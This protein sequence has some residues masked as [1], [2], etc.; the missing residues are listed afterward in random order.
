MSFPSLEFTF[1][2]KEQA[3][4][5]A[6]FHGRFS[7]ARISLSTLSGRSSGLII[8]CGLLFTGEFCKEE[9]G[10]DTVVVVGLG[11]FAGV[12]EP[13]GAVIVSLLRIEFVDF[14]EEIPFYHSCIQQ[15]W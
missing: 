1:G 12:E 15:E 5:D 8:V 11:V 9:E 10:E 7:N 14:F 13:S 6:E 4:E 2:G 3:E